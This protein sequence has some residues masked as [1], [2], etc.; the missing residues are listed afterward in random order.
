MSA[1]AIT[2][3]EVQV[4]AADSQTLPTVALEFN[5]NTDQWEPIVVHHSITFTGP[6]TTMQPMLLLTPTTVV[7]GVDNHSWGLYCRRCYGIHVCWGRFSLIFHFSRWL[8]Q[9]STVL[10]KDESPHTGYTFTPWV[11]FFTPPSIE[12]Y[13]GGTSILR[14]I[15]TTM[16]SHE[17]DS[18]NPDR[19]AWQV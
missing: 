6:Y 19:T 5:P 15:R 17:K 7:Q 8:G 4:S 10:T 13:V 14:L 9:L 16:E 2:A 12:H 11:V 3:C 18:R 1:V